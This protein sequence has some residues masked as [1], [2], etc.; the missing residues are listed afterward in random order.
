MPLPPQGCLLGDF[1]HKSFTEHRHTLWLDR[2]CPD[3]RNLLYL[4]PQGKLLINQM[5]VTSFEV[6][7]ILVYNEIK[8]KIHKKYVQASREPSAHQKC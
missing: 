4:K 2:E 3:F 8:N 6:S 5:K 7:F 1:P